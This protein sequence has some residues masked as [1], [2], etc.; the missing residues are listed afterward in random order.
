MV[1]TR[2]K[3]KKV[4]GKMEDKVT[5]ALESFAETRPLSPNIR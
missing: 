4:S 1:R 5:E 2:S 3:G